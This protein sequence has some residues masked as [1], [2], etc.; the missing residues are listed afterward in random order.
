MFERD[1]HPKLRLALRDKRELLQDAI[2]VWMHDGR[3]LIGETY[4]TPIRVALQDAD[5][6][7][8]ADLVRYRRQRAIYVYSTAIR[9]RWRGQRLSKV[10]KAYFLGR[11]AQ[12]GYEIAVGHAK[13]GA[14]C[15]LNVAFG[16][17]L[18]ARHTNWYGTGTTFRFYEMRLVP[19]EK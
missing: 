17:R 3:S 9:R 16:A 19:V 15:A 18:G 7:G 4:G 8:H 6:E 1:F 11:A 2:A 12:A 5:E 14:S 10:L 13:E